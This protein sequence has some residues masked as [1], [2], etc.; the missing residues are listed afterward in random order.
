MYPASQLLTAP[1]ASPSSP[2]ISDSSAAEKESRPLFSAAES[3]FDALFDG[4][5]ENA[6]ERRFISDGRLDEV[7]G[8]GSGGASASA[9]GAGGSALAGSSDV[10]S[11]DVVVLPRWTATAGGETVTVTLSALA[12]DGWRPGEDSAL[13]KEAVRTGDVGVPIGPAAWPDNDVVR[14][15][16]MLTFEY[17]GRTDP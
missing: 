15:L 4:E 11:S 12:K 10:G 5:V 3:R 16:G 8:G 13:V 17:D 6:P 1:T 2:Y 7:L 9:E 14:T